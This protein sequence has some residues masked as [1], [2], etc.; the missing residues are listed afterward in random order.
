VIQ[1]AYVHG[2]STRKVDDLVAALGGCHVSKSEVS[3]IC[4]ELDEELAAFR[5]RPLDD[6]AYPYV[7]FDATYEKVRE[8]GQVVSQA[9]VVALG[10]RETGEKSLLRVAVGAGA[11][12]WREFCRHLVA[13]GLRGVRLVISDAHEGLRQALA[14]CFAGAS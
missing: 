1:E 12:F 5:E 14:A 2:V 3:R 11:P 10:V 13:R 9:G 7:L 8:N 4:A 6:A